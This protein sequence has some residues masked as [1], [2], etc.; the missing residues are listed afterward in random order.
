M[1]TPAI[2]RRVAIPTT[3]GF[4]LVDLHQV[5]YGRAV[6]N[7]THFVL[8]DG[9][10]L[11]SSH[12]LKYF[13]AQLEGRGFFRIHKSYVVNGEHLVK[14]LRRGCVVLIDGT[15]LEVARSFRTA[16]LQAIT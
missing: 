14:Y 8:L 15:E 1:I 11:V 13:Q 10:P 9:T 3:D 6:G 5:V 12:T 2:S 16:L 4:V 7:Y